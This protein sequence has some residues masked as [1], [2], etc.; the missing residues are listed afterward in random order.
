M[1]L[2]CPECATSYF[3]A[4]SAIGSG[5]KVRCTICSTSWVAKPDWALDLTVSPE[6]GAVAVPAAASVAGVEAEPEATQDIL[7]RPVSE[8]AGEELPKAFRAR[9]QAERRMREAATQ[10][11]VWAGMAAAAALIAVLAVVFRLD[12]VRVWPR[13]A[14]AYAKVGLAVN[15]VGLDIEDFHALPSLQDGRPALLVSGVLRNIRAKPIVSP[16]IGITLVDAHGQQLLAKS[17][18][19]GDPLVSPGQTR[20]FTVSLV[21]P[22]SAAS[23][24]DI[25]F[26]MGRRKGAPAPTPVRLAAPA[27]APEP[28]PQP[29]AFLR[30]GPTSLADLLPDS[31]TPPPLAQSRGPDAAEAR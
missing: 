31:S 19:L 17:V 1:I 25:T 28:Q 10:G 16:P 27:P 5:R 23:E 13:T 9:A 11:V 15:S 8:L 29:A 6:E 21:D 20:A 22:P 12:V 18:S 2:T 26:V 14:S 24:V 3:A 7:D 4:D 30:R